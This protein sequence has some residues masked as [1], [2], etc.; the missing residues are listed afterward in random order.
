LDTEEKAVAWQRLGK[1]VPEATNT[2]AATELLDAVF[3]AIR[4]VSYTQHLSKGKQAIRCSQNILLKIQFPPNR[5]TTV[6]ITNTN[7]LMLLM[8]LIA[9]YSQNHIKSIMTL[10]EQNAE[11]VLSVTAGITFDYSVLPVFN[12]YSF[13]QLL[14]FHF[15][16]QIESYSVT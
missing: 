13:P 16:L 6:S 8:E 3:Y 11:F 12:A 1:H 14:S 10:C 15:I 5:K 7:L 2:H 9:V 4:V